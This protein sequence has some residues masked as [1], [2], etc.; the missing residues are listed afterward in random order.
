MLAIALSLASSVSWGVSD[1]IGGLLSRRT[2]VVAVLAISQPAGLVL[3]LLLAPPLS[4]RALPAADFAL[5]AASGAAA[6]VALGLFY[7]AMALGAISVAAPL[8]SLGV[9][10]PVAVG[11]ARGEQ[12]AAVQLVGFG[13]AMAAIALVSREPREPVGST[14]TSRRAILLAALSGLGF[15]V[16]FTGLERA[17]QTDPAW[18]I[19]AARCGGAAVAIGVALAVRPPM[20][21]AAPTFAAAVTIGG[22]DILAN[23]LYAVA[24]TKGPL[25]IVA[26]AASLYSAVTIVL[27]HLLL[28]ERLARVQLVGVALALA[29]VA[30][31]A[32]GA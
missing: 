5:A 4:D 22:F 32:A 29:A 1:F 18:T 16:F 6:M 24:T 12:P 28:G 13:V 27:A 10:V 15:G 20:P 3:A 26:V 23:G 11:L 30:L 2:A 31:I 17:A 8:A 7:R 19:A 14:P 21:R 25:A 9:V